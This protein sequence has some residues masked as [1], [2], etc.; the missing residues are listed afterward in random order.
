MT[1]KPPRDTLGPIPAEA[2]DNDF[3]PKID[4][5]RPRPDAETIERV[6][7]LEPT[8][9]RILYAVLKEHPTLSHRQA[10]DEL[11]AAGF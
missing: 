5:D 9:R 4:E 6:A 11:E 10:L 2:F 7:Q 8:Q 1:N 3:P